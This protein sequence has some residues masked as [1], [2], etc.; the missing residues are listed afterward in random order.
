M[1]IR[2]YYNLFKAKLRTVIFYIDLPPKE[3]QK[4]FCQFLSLVLHKIFSQHN[5]KI[6]VVIFYF[7][8]LL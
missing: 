7:K 5:L 2:T 3:G 6:R 1:N 4:G 8:F